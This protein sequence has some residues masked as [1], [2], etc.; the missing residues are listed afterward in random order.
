MKRYQI[1]NSKDAV[2]SKLYG[3]RAGV[4][5]TLA[6]TIRAANGRG[7]TRWQVGDGKVQTSNTVVGAVAGMLVAA[8]KATERARIR[9]L[10]RK[11][12]QASV[13]LWAL[14]GEP[15]TLPPAPAA[16]YKANGRA[17]RRTIAYHEELTLVFPEY[18]TLG[19]Y[20]PRP[21]KAEI[22]SGWSTGMPWPKGA[23]ASEHAWAG[24]NDAGKSNDHGG[25]D[26]GPMLAPLLASITEHTLANR[27]RLGV[28][29]HIY[30]RHRWHAPDF[31][32]VAY[33]GSDPHDTHTHTAFG[34]HHGEQPPWL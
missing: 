3:R 2:R 18:K 22:P 12:T 24:A 19:A 7:Q 32:E 9:T 26:Q 34:E 10:P 8:G 11:T 4:A 30:L 14:F 23:Y 31:A 5:I 28:V 15:Q 20:V 17:I 1:G 21:I 16:A 27:D 13:H 25:Y 6:R 33:T 29:D